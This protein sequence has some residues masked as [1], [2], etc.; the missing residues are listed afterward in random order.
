[1]NL[2][3]ILIS[4]VVAVTSLSIVAQMPFGIELDDSQKGFFVVGVLGILN[5]L[6]QPLIRLTLTMANLLV[7]GII[8]GLLAFAMNV[9]LLLLAAKSIDGFR[10]PW[11][12]WSAIIGAV[13]LSVASSA[14]ASLLA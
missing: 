10:L 3:N 6:L 13:A 7:L 1:M 8:S 2:L 14:I 11:G 5:A 12:I 9:I 4:L